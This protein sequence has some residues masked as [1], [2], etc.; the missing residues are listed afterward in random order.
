MQLPTLKKYLA[1][2]L[3][4]STFLSS[5]MSQAQE[6]RLIKNVENNLNL[7]VL[8][9]QKL[10]LYKFKD[11]NLGFCA[12]YSCVSCTTLEV[13]YDLGAKCQLGNLKNS[14]LYD[15]TLQGA[16]G[17]GANFN[18][19]DL[20]HVNANFGN[21][22]S[23]SFIGSTLIE[24]RF[25][26]AT[27]T[28]AYFEPV[29]TF[30]A[31]FHH[32]DL[33]GSVLKGNFS[34]ADFLG[35]NLTNVNMD[36]ANFVGAKFSHETIFDNTNVT[37]T[38]FSGVDS[39]RMTYFGGTNLVGMVGLPVFN[40]DYVTWIDATCPDGTLANDNGVDPTCIG[41]FIP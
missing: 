24:T 25:F 23:A 29:D 12:V 11:L 35:A 33:T 21:F 41:H 8:D 39:F 30:N 40:N 13:D 9:P 19:A 14:D 22:N 36:N 2:S 6:T 5:I 7:N 37:G 16:N 15:S 38:D 18:L 17:S 4:T 31:E 28:N 1:I 34:E 10:F 20:G 32:T 26:K 3:I 27:M